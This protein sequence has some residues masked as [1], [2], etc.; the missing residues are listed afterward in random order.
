MP[1][2][3]WVAS[4]L[5]T[6]SI[7]LTL[8][9]LL[10]CQLATMGVLMEANHTRPYQQTEAHRAYTNIAHDHMTKFQ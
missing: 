8:A 1:N 10:R 4:H 6:K 7:S 5:F 3:A 2:L 9:T